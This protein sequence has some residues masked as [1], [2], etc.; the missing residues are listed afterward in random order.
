MKRKIMICAGAEIAL[1]ALSFM[2]TGCGGKGGS[3]T[4]PESGGS[5][6]GDGHPVIIELTQPGC[7]PCAAAEALI[8]AL[9]KGK[10]GRISFVEIDVT[11]DREAARKYG[12]QA[13]PTLVILDSRGDQTWSYVGVPPE[14]ELAAEIERVISP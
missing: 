6:L 5:A 12:V 13:T 3:A 1:V 10:E 4:H 11:R 9:L 8:Q 2:L 14:R 7:P